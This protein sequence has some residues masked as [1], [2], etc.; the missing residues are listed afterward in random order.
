MEYV[1]LG[2]PVIAARTPT[3]AAY[4][5]DSMVQFFEPGN[6]ADLARCVVSLHG[7]RQRLARLVAAS[8]SFNRKYNWENVAAGYVALVDRLGAREVTWPV[9][10]NIKSGQSGRSRGV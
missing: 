9:Q 4:F 10:A 2:I 6:V 5:D 1:A 8:D 3:I 7:D